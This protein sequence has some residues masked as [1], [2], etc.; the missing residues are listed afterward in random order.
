MA[1]EKKIP[2]GPGEKTTAIRLGGTNFASM[3]GSTEQPKIGAHRMVASITP[4]SHQMFNRGILTGTEA[5]VA[6]A[7]SE[8]MQRAQRQGR[9]AQTTDAGDFRRGET[10]YDTIHCRAAVIVKLNAAQTGKGRPV[11]K[12]VAKNGDAWLQRESK[13]KKK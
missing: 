10:V 9:Q 13:L 5:E 8:E 3:F 6:L 2:V 4:P 7:R 1:E 11:H 12:L